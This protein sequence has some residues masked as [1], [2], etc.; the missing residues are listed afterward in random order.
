M[1]DQIFT[2]SAVV[3]PKIQRPYNLA[4]TKNSAL[5]ILL[6]FGSSGD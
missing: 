6:L 3:R 2:I 4:I 1:R 5:T